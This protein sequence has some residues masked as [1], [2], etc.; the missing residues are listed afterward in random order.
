MADAIVYRQSRRDKH[1]NL[2]MATELVRR[3]PTQAELRALLHYN[4]ETGVFTHLVSRGKGKAGAVA[5]GL[6]RHGYW[7]LRVLNRLFGAQRLA[8]L[9]M[10]G[11]L[12]EQPISIDHINGV[13]ADNRW[14][15]LRLATYHE[16]SWNAPAHHHNQSGL[17]GAWPCKQTGR[18]MSMLQ[19]GAERVWLGRFDTAQEAHEAIRPVDFAL[20]PESVKKYLEEHKADLKDT[21]R[22]GTGSAADI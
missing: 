10:T 5:G 9:Y 2:R 6:N 4:P 21:Q 13:R 12:P 7:E 20:P 15:N 16:Q 22:G 8:W 19:V 18:W 14:E 11:E 3:T 17:K 1:G